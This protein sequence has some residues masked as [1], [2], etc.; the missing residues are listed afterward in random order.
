MKVPDIT[1]VK[2]YLL[3]LQDRL[4][5]ALEETD[6]N[7]RFI[8]DVWQRPEGGGGRTRVLS[9]GAVF[10]QVGVNFSHVSGAALPASATAQRPELARRRYQAMGVSLVAHPRNPYV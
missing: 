2:T 5:A 4:C 10:E 7:A 6:A 1:A 9:E 3:T 8:E